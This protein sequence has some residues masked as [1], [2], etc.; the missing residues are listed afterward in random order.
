[1]PNAAEILT[2]QGFNRPS[3]LDYLEA[4]QAKA[5]EIFGEDVDLT[6]ETAM[7]QWINLVSYRDAEHAELAEKVY[8]SGS[9]DTAEDFALDY[10]VKRGAGITRFSDARAKGKLKFIVAPGATVAKDTIIA[11]EKG[12]SVRTIAA[13]T[14]TEGVG[15]VLADAMAVDYGA[16]G[17]IGANTALI[18]STPQE[19]VQSVTNPEAFT[20]GRLKESDKELRSR[21][22][23]S[24]AR[25]GSATTDAV[26][27]AILEIPDVRAAFVD[28]NDSAEVRNGLP[29]H[30]IAPVVL[31][32]DREAIAKAIH[33]KKA[34]GIQSYGTETVMVTDKSGKQRTIGFSYATNSEIYVKVALSK[35]AAF[36]SNGVKEVTRQIIEYIG[37]TDEDGNTYS[38]LGMGETVYLSRV[39]REITV[40]GIDDLTV[41]LRLGSSGEY[42]T[43]NIPISGTNVAQTDYEKVVVTFE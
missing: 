12:V 33:S 15:L 18:I 35:N 13:V 24:I 32:G 19:G 26:N 28:E 41:Y 21:Y 22:Y 14:D 43:E 37:G 1:M 38:G 27:A 39:M 20:G 17:N 31:G 10:A 6:E 11:T 30:C 36:P 25:G 8:L 5:R 34:G 2:P 42:V 29:P 4:N 23:M 7:G 16:N 40:S 3:Y 9:V